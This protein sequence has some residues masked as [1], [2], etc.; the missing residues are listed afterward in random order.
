LFIICIDDYGKGCTIFKV[1]YRSGYLFFIPRLSL[2]TIAFLED[3][4]NASRGLKLELV[5]ILGRTLLVSE[6]PVHCISG[7]FLVEITIFFT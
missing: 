3:G 4:G 7:S 2:G 1:L 5:I 6:I